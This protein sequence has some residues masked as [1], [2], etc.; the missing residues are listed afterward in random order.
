MA[1]ALPRLLGRV[2]AAL[3]HTQYA[4]P[5]RCPCPGIVTVHDLSF[6]RDSTLM[7]RRDRFVFRLV[8]PRSARRAARVL[9]VSER[10]R[11]DLVECYGLAPA[12]V[13]VTPNGFDPV[14][15]PGEGGT[16][17]LRPRRRC[18][19]AAQ[20]SGRGGRGREGGRT[21]ARR[22]RA[23]EGRGRRQATPRERG[24]VAG[25]RRDR[26]A[27]RALPGRGLP[28]PA[29]PLRGLRPPRA[30]G[31][32]ERDAGRDRPRRCPDGGGRGCRR[33]R[34]EMP[35]LRA[36][37]GERSPIARRSS[38]PAWSARAP[39]RGAQRQNGRSAS[40][41][42]LSADDRFRRR[43]LSRSRGRARAIARRPR[44][45]GRPDRGR[46]ESSRLGR[47]AAAGCAGGREPEAA[48][49]RGQR[50]RRD[51]ARRPART[52]S[53]R[54]RTRSPRPVPWPSWSRSWTRTRGAAS[55]ARG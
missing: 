50:Q 23:R 51:R 43:R 46:L 31:D 52:C 6:E 11:R 12:A 54:T 19:A 55:Q 33:G 7:P 20:E 4:L 39:S 9:T 8:V 45:T 26:R 48:L 25:V 10:S 24:D 28:G 15:R 34:R 5:W 22:R 44:S 13:V 16:P 35:T 40:T 3:V 41:G 47:G 18:R 30:G 32:G 53:P 17:R 36:E 27:G 38:P 21:A 42:R 2:G 14:F 29:V 37:S 49:A 1:W